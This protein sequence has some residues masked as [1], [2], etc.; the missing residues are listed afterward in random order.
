MIGE[1]DDI[2]IYTADPAFP[3]FDAAFSL[4]P[5][6][7]GARLI[8]KLAFQHE[9][10]VSRCLI[11]HRWNEI[12]LTH[13]IAHV[14][15]EGDSFAV[16]VHRN[17]HL[18]QEPVP[19]I[20]VEAPVPM[21][22]DANTV[23]PQ[24]NEGPVLLQ[25]HSLLFAAQGQQP[26]QG[27]TLCDAPTEDS[28]DSCPQ[29]VP[30]RVIGL[31]DLKDLVPSFITISGGV[32]V[33]VV[34]LELSNFGHLGHVMLSSNLTLAV[35]SPEIWPFEEDKLLLLF[36]DLKQD[37]PDD[38]ST[39][40]TLIDQTDM[41]EIQLMSL[42]HKLGYDKAVTQGRKYLHAAFLEIT[43]AQA[44]GSPEIAQ[45]QTKQQKPWPT[46]PAGDRRKDRPMW[47]AQKEHNTHSCFLDLGIS[48]EDLQAFF[49]GDSDYLCNVTEELPVPAVTSEAIATLKQH[50]QFDRLI[51][52]ADGSSQ[53]KHKHIAPELNEE[54]DVPDAWCFLVLGETFIDK[55]TSEC[56]LLGWQTHQVRYDPSHPWYIGANQ[57]GSAIAER[58]ALTW[59]F[60]W[61]LG[62]NTCLPTIFR[63]DSLLTIGQAEGSLGTAECD[64][65]F[66]TLRGCYQLLK[67][68]L[69]DDVDLDH[70]FGHLG[71]PWN[72]MTD[73][74]AKQEARSSYFLQRPP[75]DLPKLLPKIPF[76]WMI[77]STE[78]GMPPFVGTGFDISAP[79]L[80]NVVAPDP[81]ATQEPPV[82]KQVK[83]QL[84]IATAN[85]QSLGM[86]DQGFAG[87]LDYLRAQFVDM[88][89]NLLGLQESRSAEGVSVKQGVFRLC[90]GHSKGRWGVELWVN[91]QQPFAYIKKKA[92]FFRAQDFHVAHRDPRHLL[93]HIHHMHFTSWCLVA[94]APQSGIPMKD[95]QNWWDETRE[96]LIKYLSAD[97][98]L[99][100]CIDANAAPGTQDGISV[101]TSGFRHSSGTPLL[102]DFLDA[103]GLC[104]PITHTIHQ[105][106]VATWTSPEDGEYTIDYVAIPRDWIA[107]CHHSKV[108]TEFDL[109]NI[110][111]DHSAVALELQWTQTVPTR[112]KVS[113]KKLSFDR[114]RIDK[115]LTVQL[116][117]PIHCTWKEDVESQANKIADH[118]HKHLASAYPKP[119][120]GPKKPYVSEEIWNM[121]AHKH[122]L[123]RQLRTCRSLLRREA[124]AR[125][126]IAW[127]AG[128]DQ[129]S[130][131]ALSFNYGT[132]LRIG[133][134]RC[135]I[136]FAITSAKLRKQILQS[137]SQKLQQVMQ[138]ID[139]S[140][141]ASRIQQLLKP[142]KGPSNKLRQGLAP[143][144]L[145]KD[146]RGE[147]CRTA[148]DALQRWVTFFGDMEGGHRAS[149][150]EQWMRWRTN[151]ETFLQQEIAIPVEEIPTLCELEQACR[152]AAAGKATGLDDIPSE[153]C[154]FC[155]QAV[156]LH[157]YSLMLKTCA[158]GQEA[159]SH[160]GGILLP[161]WKGKQVKDQC[162]AFRSILLSSCLGKVMHKAVRMKQLDLYQQFMHHQQLGGRRRVPV[163]LG[164]HQVRAFHRL[165][166]RKGQPSALL[167]IDLQ[168]A[169]YRVIRPL[170]VDGPIDDASIAAMAARIQLDDGFLHDLHSALQQPSALEEAGIPGHLRRAIRALHTDTFF[171]LPTQNDQVV[172]QI[173]TRPG[174]S[175]ADVIF[176][177]LMAKVLHKFQ[178]AME[179]QGLLLHLPEEETISFAEAT[180]MGTIPF[181]GP[182]WM[183]DLCVCLTATTNEA[184]ESA[185]GVAVGTILDIFKSYAMTPNLQ[186]GKTAVLVTP[187]GPGTHQWKKRMFGPLATGHFLSLGEHHSYQVPIV[188]EYQHLGGKVHFSTKLTKE[189]KARLGQA[190]Q[191]FNRHR[192]LLYH[193]KHF[194]MDKKKELFQSLILSR[195]LF[196]AETW[197]FSDQKTREYLHGSIMGLIKRLLHCQGHV[198]LSD[199]EVLYRTRMPSPTNLLRICR[200]RY[201]G[202]LLAVDDKACWGLLNQDRDWLE[203]VKDDFRWMWH[204]LHHCCNLGDP[205]EH[206]PRWLEIIRF[207]RGYWKRLV[208]RASEHSIGIQDRDF[209][210][211]TAHSRFLRRLVEGQFLI[212]HDPSGDWQSRLNPQAFGCMTCQKAFRSLGGEGAH[213]H[214]VHGEVNPVRHLIGGTQCNA[215]LTEYYTTGKLKMHLRR[216]S[217][218]RTSLIGRGHREAV[219]PG[220]GSIEDSERLAQW[221]NKIPPLIAAGPRLPEGQRRDFEVEHRVLYEVVTLGIME[222][223]TDDYE[224][225]VRQQIQEQ[226]ISWTRCQQ[227]LQEVLRQI[228]TGFPDVDVEHLHRC[229]DILKRLA[230]V[231]AW[232][233]LDQLQC[234]PPPAIPTVEDMHQKI[235]EAQIQPDRQMIPRPIGKE[236]VFLH[237]FSGRRRLGD[238][239]HYLEAAFSRNA[240]GVLLHVI[241][242]DVVIDQEWGNACKPET[243]DFWLR[244]ALN[245]YVHGGLCG[246]PCETWSQARFAD[247]GIEGARQ[248]RPLR[249]LEWLWGLPSL[250]LREMSQIAVGN[251]LLLF[252]LDLLI[253]LAHSE[254]LGILEH[255]GEPEDETKPSIWRLP[256]VQLLR[257]LPGFEYVDFAQG[258]L[259]A[260]SPKPTRLL[261]L[262]LDSLPR[263]LHSHRLCPDLPKNA[264]IGKLHDGQWATSSLKEYP[265]ALNRALGESIA[266]HLLQKPH[267]K[268]SVIDEEFLSR[269][270]SM[271]VDHFG[272]HFG[273][274]YYLQHRQKPRR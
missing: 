43:F 243:R 214:R 123:R 68:A 228:D 188:T 63:S 129:D 58:E 263:F 165:C 151:L 179:E 137:R 97:E 110:N 28:S 235:L 104:L 125:V 71:D 144:P 86:P 111:L 78:H 4:R 174:D 130:N 74:L 9:C 210:V 103:F 41:S 12:P 147:F 133:S 55:S 216:S 249:S 72:E 273:P 141:P 171:K 33:E 82:I 113:S 13:E 134:L 59:A 47:T 88:N 124:L 140:T 51:I 170:V 234:R 244:G 116:R 230:T 255:P 100:A 261:T 172:T 34:Q 60:L 208:R 57:V 180:T 245:G 158:H 168:E 93:V 138:Q 176:G 27:V 35:C 238:L 232:P 233:F 154:K 14:M 251:E 5:Y 184:L 135:Y 65:S 157:L 84:S 15:T 242:M 187:R 265:P 268:E 85:V 252:S 70:V 11:F 6:V 272:E 32:S 96:I 183:D 212:E 200:L 198:P 206:L 207:H 217:A 44:G 30:I 145:I 10:Q 259:G 246:P 42:L 95:R 162:S 105:G 3:R 247:L 161:I 155:P 54:L 119:K 270:R 164:G 36:T 156:A 177:Y 115:E 215:C 31:G 191:E 49:H 267:Q 186:P 61:R 108:L 121:R 20:P 142:F 118:F 77:F 204:Q 213:M 94:H 266:H 199:E 253:C 81:G 224:E 18:I 173:G 45:E 143:L 128:H 39:F 90:S 264:A 132:S 193:N 67:S 248:P 21:E 182:C 241:S 29:E 112:T 76:L 274:D 218:C 219:Q 89:L 211:A 236:R 79:A 258:L 222:I 23:E 223:D 7:S 87:K 269:C 185:L 231:E 250:A 203:L 16:H 260:K 181:V 196:G 66:Q 40:L 136:E 202:S 131:L 229:K 52:Y 262:N 226:C 209:L 169:F 139:P 146:A 178:Q 26:E 153:I 1:K 37:F 237:A 197:T 24:D 73:A 163:T 201:L 122:A 56:T 48:R 149:H 240:E 117:Q 127:R 227:T 25:L 192:K 160:K 83:F 106:T 205:T 8:S 92:L 120:H 102:R 75:F 98:P 46:T 190:H 107:A 17:Q 167:F 175:F 256:I 220:L 99:F 38:Q 152:A 195:L 257:Q 62:V 189:I 19:Q 271:H 166:T 159:L 254:G 101:F 2:Y 148:D 239:Q 114:S 53:S 64:L 109:A 126:F 225:F 221:D 22:I 50:T 91:L 194:Q 80:P 69:G 150:S